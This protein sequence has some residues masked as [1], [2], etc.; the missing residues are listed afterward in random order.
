[1]GLFDLVEE[2]H[3]VGLP[4]HGFGQLPALA[5]A[6]IAGRGADQAGDVVLFGV[7]AHVDAD[8]SA[9]FVEEPFRNLPGQQGLADARGPDEEKDADR[10]VLVL[11]SGSCAEDRARHA[12][13]G[14]V[15]PHDAACEVVGE[16]F[17][18]LGLAVR[19][20]FGRDSGHRGDDL[21]DLLF[22]DLRR[23]VFERALPFGAA[24]VE[25]RPQGDLAHPCRSGL[26]VDGRFD[27]LASFAADFVQ[28]R[29]QGAQLFGFA[30]RAE[31]RPRTGLVQYVDRL[32][33][34]AAVGDVALC[35]RH[36]GFERRFRV[37]DP[38]VALVVGR[39]VVQDAERLFGGR[40]LDRHLL[41]A[42]FE[43]RIAFDVRAVFVER[44]GA[45]GL[46]FAAGQCRFEDVC[47]VEASLGGAG[48]DDGVD[49]VDEE[50]RVPVAAQ[51]VEELLHALLELA[52]EL[53]PG[54]ERRDVE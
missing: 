12:L 49:L 19:E 14:F 25:L 46:E 43:R 45:D 42:P 20:P 40:G 4:P 41:E 54:H 22:G 47:R 38:V 52:A 32:V 17:Q 31:V 26:F 33:G 36:A 48:A 1:M 5:V 35:E 6:D 29:L 7:F 50:D 27:G 44:R 30:G 2:H 10:T 16:C 53:R 15:L 37:A 34:E 18:P 21:A 24:L 9:S 3:G 8:H 11:Q 13:H 28:F 51:F 23:V 39:D